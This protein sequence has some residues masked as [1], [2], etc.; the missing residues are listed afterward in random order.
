MQT[1]ARITIGLLLAAGIF[2]AGYTANQHAAPADSS[3]SVKHVLSYTCP[4]HPQYKSD[5]PGD[6]PLCGMRLVPADASSK[7]DAASDMPGMVQISAD[8]QQLI[9]V[10]TDEVRRA[11]SSHLLRVPGRIA[12]DDQ[13]LYR[14]VAAAD[15]WIV[16]RRVSDERGVGV[17]RSSRL[18][19]KWK[20]SCAP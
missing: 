4:M 12:V 5:H 16:L 18:A 19:P 2:L 1:P 8:K 15:G 17:M 9:G 6:C 3:T 11:P 7:T 13:R 20:G 14:I 10:R